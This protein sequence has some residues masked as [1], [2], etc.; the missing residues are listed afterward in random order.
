MET[1]DAVVAESARLLGFDKLKELCYFAKI[2]LAA[3]I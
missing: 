3:S 2:L 1:I